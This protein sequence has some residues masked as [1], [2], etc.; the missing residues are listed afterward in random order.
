[1]TT[2]INIKCDVEKIPL[3]QMMNGWIPTH[4][5]DSTQMESHSFKKH[6]LTTYVKSSLEIICP[7]THWQWAISF[8]IYVPGC[9]ETMRLSYIFEDHVP[10]GQITAV[11]KVYLASPFSIPL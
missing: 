3:T 11:I 10:R 1:M 4:S 5:N 6:L 2:Q 9:R 8:S 7:I